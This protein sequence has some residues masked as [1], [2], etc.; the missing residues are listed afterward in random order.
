MLV[1]I[2]INKN[3]KKEEKKNKVKV[4]DFTKVMVEVEFDKFEERDV[5][6]P[7]AN[8]I[9]KNTGDI[10]LDEI[11]RE[12]YKKGKASIPEVYYPVIKDIMTLPECTLVVC[13]KKAIIDLF[14]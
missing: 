6:K 9:H 7:L 4:F 13:A 11:A 3:M 12:I 2:Y 8:N 14:T 10:G 5:S 1:I